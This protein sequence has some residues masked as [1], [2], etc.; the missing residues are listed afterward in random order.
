VTGEVKLDLSGLGRFDTSGR[1]RAEPGRRGRQVQADFEQRPD[2]RRLVELVTQAEPVERP[3]GARVSPMVKL[4]ARIGLGVTDFGA[5]AYSNA[6]FNGRLAVT[7][8]SLA[9]PPERLRWA[10]SPTRWTPPGLDAIPIIAT[11][12]FFVGAVIAFL[13]A[14]LL[15]QFGATIFAVELI[16]I[17]VLREF[18]VLLTAILLAGRSASAT[19]RRSVR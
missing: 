17:G 11:L 18:G 7:L 1:L 15:A 10:A 4:L 14:S 12:S 8:A 2:V 16:G 3:A 6:V 13:G 19:P 5:Q 9:G